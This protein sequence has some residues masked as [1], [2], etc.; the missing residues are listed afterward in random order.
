[1][2]ENNIYIYIYMPLSNNECRKLSKYH[3]ICDAGRISCF[4]SGL[5][6]SNYSPEKSMEIS[7]QCDKCYKQRKKYRDNCLSVRGFT[8][9]KGH[10]FAIKIAK[11]I[12]KSC[13]I[14][15]KSIKKK[16]NNNNNNS[17]NIKLLIKYGSNG[18]EGDGWKKTREKLKSLNNK[19]SLIRAKGLMRNKTRRLELLSKINKKKSSLKK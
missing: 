5:S 2:F 18:F 14:K 17:N 1:V 9:D 6:C 16:K 11:D 8:K 19:N 10:D 12:A 7:V 4:N 15:K 3:S 13:S